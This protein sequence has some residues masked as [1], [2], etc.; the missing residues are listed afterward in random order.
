MN[1]AAAP[2]LTT[3]D[4]LPAGMAAGAAADLLLV[5][6]TILAVPAGLVFASLL[7]FVA[8]GPA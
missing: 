8:M 7:L 5:L 1:S 3:T 2:D 6:T 4:T